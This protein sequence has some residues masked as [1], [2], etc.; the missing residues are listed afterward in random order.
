MLYAIGEIVKPFGIH[1]E[2]VVRP[3]T[4]RPARFRKLKAVLV[5]K[6]HVPPTVSGVSIVDVRGRGVRLKLSLAGNRTEA[7]NLVGSLLYIEVK[8]R[9]KLPRGTYFTHDIVGLQVINQHDKKVGV[10]REV[11]KLNAHDIYVLD[12]QGKEVMVPAVRDFV[13]KVDLAAGCIRIHFIEG[14]LGDDAH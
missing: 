5:G 6:P 11:L 12:L 13:E 2:V 7:E 10:V 14:M 3:L 9:L 1:G 8:D 4:D